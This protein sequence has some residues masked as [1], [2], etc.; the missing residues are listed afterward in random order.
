MSPFNSTLLI[1]VHH[2]RIEHRKYQFVCFC[3]MLWY[4]V[5]GYKLNNHSSTVCVNC[6][7]T[8]N[9]VE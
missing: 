3:D 2:E 4:N 9:F 6:Y 7:K 5:N 1:C 8:V